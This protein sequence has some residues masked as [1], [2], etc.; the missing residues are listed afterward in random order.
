MYHGQEM[1]SITP[2]ILNVTKSH[3]VIWKATKREN[4]S[5]MYYSLYFLVFFCQFEQ[6][7]AKR[8]DKHK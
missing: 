4:V 7:F 1:K 3:C 5:K 2:Y 8:F 6:T